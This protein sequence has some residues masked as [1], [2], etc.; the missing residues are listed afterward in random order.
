[1]VHPWFIN[2][3]FIGFVEL[4][5]EI[6]HITPQLKETLNVDL[7][8]LIDKSFLSREMWEEGLKM[9]GRNG[10]WDHLPDCVITNS[11]I[12]VLPPEFIKFA[13]LPHDQHQDRLVSATFNGSTYRAGFV[14]LK[15]A[16]GRE[17]GDILVIKNVSADR[18]SLR[19]LLAVVAVLCSCVGVLLFVFFYAHIASIE[20]HL[21]KTRA[22]LEI[23]IEKR[24]QTET[25]LR[26]HRDNLEDLVK[27]RT[28]ELEKTN[29]LLQQEIMQR[30]KAEKNLENLNA[31]LESTV[32]QLSQSNKQLGDFA[33]I[34]AHDLKT[35]LRG[36]GMLAQWLAKDYHDNFDDNGRRQID[37]LVRRVERMDNLIDVMLQ[38]S[39]IA[40]NRQNERR[41]D[42]PLL[43]KS[44]L[45]EIQP[46]QNIKITINRDLPAIIC[47]EKHIAQVF[48]NL[49][50][51]AVRFMDKPEGRVTIDFE[52]EKYFWKFSIADNGPG[53]EPQHFERI[54]R[55]FQKLGDGDQSENIGAGLTI[56]KKIVELYDGKIWLTSQPGQGSTFFF[57][58]PKQPADV[59]TQT[60]QPA[61]T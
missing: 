58:L 52:D 42:L 1:M 43:L 55:L 30:T 32:A 27:T 29:K 2:D 14:Q 13:G 11:T 12:P 47:D 57:T 45:N 56:T 4:G 3:T 6:E 25:E 36:I 38:Y 18:A 39:T 59:T 23:E 24:K 33:H 41:L 21:I 7:V 15:D 16:A 22:S 34:T 40:R 44:V 60:P 5:E 51:N 31:D 20:K 61:Q 9:M 46:P 28:A 19:A 49:L 17:V 8:F 26:K 10:N 54:F 50:S 53:I 48:Y 37:L 35:P